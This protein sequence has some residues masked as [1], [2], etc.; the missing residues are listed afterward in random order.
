MRVIRE[1]V[2]GLPESVH[3]V[4]ARHK[5]EGT[6]SGI[7]KIADYRDGQV[8]VELTVK[9]FGPPAIPS[10]HPSTAPALGPAPW[11]QDFRGAAVATLTTGGLAAAALIALV[12]AIR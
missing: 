4:V 1:R 11:Y 7:E 8:E 6:L 2:I 5:V 9:D 3:A 12:E 10:Y